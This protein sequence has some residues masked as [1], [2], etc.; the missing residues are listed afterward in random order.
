MHKADLFV[1]LS[2]ISVLLSC[3]AE[4]ESGVN[5]STVTVDPDA[6]RNVVSL[7]IPVV[8]LCNELL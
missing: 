5:E 1:I 2:I 8:L 6:K 3:D 7:K 4:N